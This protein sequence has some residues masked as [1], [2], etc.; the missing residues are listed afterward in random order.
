MRSAVAVSPRWRTIQ[1][2]ARSIGIG[3]RRACRARRRRTAACR[4]RSSRRGRDASTGETGAEIAHDVAEEIAEQ[5]H[6][7]VRRPTHEPHAQRVDDDVVGRDVG[8]G[9][10]D[11]A[12]G[13]EEEPSA[14]FMMFALWTIDTFLRPCDRARS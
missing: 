2:A 3:R 5:E 4:R 8:V 14:R 10:A 6:V 12:R 1:R 11:L 13:L 9:L 7:E